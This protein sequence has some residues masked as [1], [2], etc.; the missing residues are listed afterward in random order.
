MKRALHMSARS[1]VAA[2]GVATATSVLAAPYSSEA[3]IVVTG[4]PHAGPHSLKVDDVGCELRKR[5]GRPRY[6]NDNF[7]KQDAKGPKQLSFVVV[8]IRNADGSG[9]PA[10]AE[11]EASVTFGP[12]MGAGSTFYMS[13]SNA[14]TGRVGGPGT[15]LLKE[16]GKI[17]QVVLDLQPQAGIRVTGTVRCSIIQVP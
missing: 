14:T 10:P 4:G 13:G 9:S 1:V 5:P 12:V 8:N 17:A 16:D 2:I 3:S 6:F 11:F 7:G 15:V